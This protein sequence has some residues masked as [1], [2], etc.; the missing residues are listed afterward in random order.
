MMD[1]IQPRQFLFWAGVYV[2][3]MLCIMV[4]TCALDWYGRLQERRRINH[5][6]GN[7]G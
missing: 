1:L 6:R 5:K 3:L 2:G 7:H 4:L